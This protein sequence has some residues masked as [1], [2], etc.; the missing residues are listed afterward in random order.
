MIMDIFKTTGLPKQKGDI[1]DTT[2]ALQANNDSQLI[3]LAQKS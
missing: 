1:P 2:A 3:Q